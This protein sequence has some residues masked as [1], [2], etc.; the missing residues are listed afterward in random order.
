M[1]YYY[2]LLLAWLATTCS[3]IQKLRSYYKQQAHRQEVKSHVLFSDHIF[4]FD[5][6]RTILDAA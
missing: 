2:V 3:V 1:L 6:V 4:F 5:R